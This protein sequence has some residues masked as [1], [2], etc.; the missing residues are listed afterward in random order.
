MDPH[1]WDRIQEI[2]YSA[3]PIPPGQ[4]CDFV[5]RECDFDPVLTKQVCSLLKADS[6][7]QFLE[8]PIFRLGLRILSTDDPTEL[9]ISDSNDELI[10][11]TIDDRYVV[12]RR[13][14]KG[15]MA[16]VYLARD[17]TLDPKRVVLK[18]LLDESLRNAEIVRKFK[19]EKRALAHVVHPGVVTILGAG[20]LPDK[21]PYLVM[22]YV[23][24]ASLRNLI[25]EK[26][27]GLPFERA[28]FIIRG[29]GSALNAV[30][31][32]EIYHRDLKPENIMLQDLGAN[33]EQVKVVDF[34]IAKVKASLMGPTNIEDSVTMGTVAYMSPE[35]LHGDR[36]SA[37]SDV[38]SFAV[39]AYELLT[40]RRPFVFETPAD[41]WE[42]Q[43]Q[44]IRA[45]PTALR[46]K[47]S[48]EAEAIILNGLSFDPGARYHAGEFGNRL[49]SAL[50]ANAPAHPVVGRK[51]RLRERFMIATAA[52]LL[53][54]MVT[55]VY[56]L[57][58][59]P[60][61]GTATNTRSSPY[62]TLSY[63][64][65]VQKM[66]GG[67]LY[68]EPFE[69]AEPNVFESGDKFRL[70]VFKRQAGH[71]YVFSQGPPEQEV[72]NII[73]PTK[74]ANDG[75]ARLEQNQDFQTNWN[76][77]T[78]EK[79]KERLWI[80]WS[81]AKVVPLEV[82]ALDAFKSPEGAVTDTSIV[83]TLRDFL[84]EN[85]TPEPKTTKDTAKQRTSVW[86]SGN[87]LVKLVELEHQ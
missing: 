72:F 14:A 73:F 80:V 52:V 24:G 81:Q 27:Q 71:L 75:T 18:V 48:E 70:N 16:R 54:A 23:A 68:Q 40:G 76:T 61:F 35:Q 86:A 62:R 12:E 8:A 67:Q 47:L 1:T 21:K 43:R 20:E 42:L 69:S 45:K 50:L 79:G 44:G 31:R 74:A 36:V 46:P 87:L 58:W 4:R 57:I 83:K 66:R 26:P 84:S 49:S 85:S 15:G 64:F 59:R 34:G 30:H 13:L 19:E 10:G 41:L 82:A 55:G 22:E 39:V 6:S 11:S 17:L 78:G 51:L 2:Y 33:E 38:Y 32:N 9:D 56:W 63:S 25:N 65:T 60:G 5:A 28:A 29:I 53:L 3:L 37:P 77:F 7:A